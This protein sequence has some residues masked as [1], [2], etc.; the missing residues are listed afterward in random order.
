LVSMM[1]CP[2]GREIH[3]KSISSPQAAK[4]LTISGS[5]INIQLD[6]DVGPGVLNFFSTSC[7]TADETVDLTRPSR[8]IRRQIYELDHMGQVIV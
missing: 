7:A 8:L 1:E 2:P 3:R 6:K 4:I 5:Y